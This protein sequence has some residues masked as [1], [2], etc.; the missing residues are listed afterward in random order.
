MTFAFHMLMKNKATSYFLFS[1]WAHATCS[2]YNSAK[3]CVLH[4][5]C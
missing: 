5:C 1:G 3:N 4:Y 2:T